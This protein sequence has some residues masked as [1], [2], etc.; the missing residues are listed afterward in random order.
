MQGEK[1]SDLDD[2]DNGAS[3]VDTRRSSNSSIDEETSNDENY[4][5]YTPETGVPSPVP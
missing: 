5:T 1:Y 4:K 3:D 2:S